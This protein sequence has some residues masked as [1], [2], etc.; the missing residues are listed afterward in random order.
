MAQCAYLAGI[1]HSPNSYKPFADEPNMETI[2]N[3][4]KTVLNKM[5]DL[6]K[7]TKEEYDGA[8]AEINS[9]SG[10]GFQKTEAKGTN[11]SYH[12]DATIAQV[13]ED[14]AK[15]KD[16]STSLAST[17]LY[18]SGLTIYSTQDTNLQSQMDEVMVNDS[19]SYKRNSKQ[20][21][22]YY[23]TICNGYYR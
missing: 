20:N 22:R 14:I 11:Y 4:T 18:T 6:Q 19:D 12:T 1:N 10:L 2:N 5:L 3:R 7:I 15:Q 17:Y 9:E 16:I 13:I 8:V 23:F 21:P